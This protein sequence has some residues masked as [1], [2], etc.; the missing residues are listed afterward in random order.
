MPKDLTI[1]KN[2]KEALTLSSL[3]IRFSKILTDFRHNSSVCEKIQSKIL[4]E[5]ELY[6]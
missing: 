1:S 4:L 6:K 5:K 2:F 3:A